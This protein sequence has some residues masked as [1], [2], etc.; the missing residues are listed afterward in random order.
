MKT[1]GKTGRASACLLCERAGL[2]CGGP[3]GLAGGLRQAP[4]E[5]G[6]ARRRRSLPKT[7]GP[8]LALRTFAL[9]TSRARCARRRGATPAGVRPGGAASGGHGGGGGGGGGA[10]DLGLQA[11]IAADVLVPRLLNSLRGI[12]NRSVIASTTAPGIL[13][14]DRVE[15]ELQVDE[16]SFTEAVG[17]LL[18]WHVPLLDLWCLLDT[19]G[20]YTEGERTVYRAWLQTAVLALGRGE[21]LLELTPSA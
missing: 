20:G 13:A 10:R 15:H 4:L 2:L 18:S 5:R 9:K 14:R 1:R 12:W 19:D 11:M 3:A 17:N 8:T 21:D 6:G 7:T 16:E